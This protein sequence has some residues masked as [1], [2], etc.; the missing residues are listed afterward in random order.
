LDHYQ[1]FVI[2]VALDL[3][4]E[5]QNGRTYLSLYDADGAWHGYINANSVSIAAGPQGGW[6]ADSGYAT[7]T[8]AGQ[9]IYQGFDEQAATTSDQYLGQTF[10]ITG[11]YHWFDGT[12]YVSLYD[13][14]GKWVGYMAA[15]SFTQGTNAQGP[16]Q[17]H[18][19]WV[20]VAH[21]GYQ[22]WK[23]FAFTHYTKAAANQVVEVK[24]VYHHVNGSIYDSVYDADGHWLGYVNA[25]AVTPIADPIGQ[26]KA[27]DRYVTVTDKNAQV[28]QDTQFTKSDSADALYQHTYHVVGEYQHVNGNTYLVLHD[29]QDQL[30]GIVSA[31]SVAKA[32]GPQGVWLGASGYVTLN[33]ENTLSSDF[34][35]SQV[36]T[37]GS[38]VAG[39]TYKVTGQ[40]HTFDGRV[41]YSVY[42]NKQWLGYIDSR[43]VKLVASQTGSW[44][45]KTG[46][47]TTT[48]KGEP[49][50]RSFFGSSQ[51]TSSH[52][53]STY[54]IKGQ[55]HAYTG[56]TYYS[57]YA[58]NGGWLGYINA[59]NGAFASGPQGAWMAHSGKVTL[60]HTGYPIWKGFFTN[61][62]NTT[63]KL[64][65]KQYSATGEYHHFNGSVYYSLYS[66]K[67]WIGYVN[68]AATTPTKKS[69]W[70]SVN[71]VLK[72]YDQTKA[73][74]TK[75]FSLVYYS[76]LDGRWAGK[77]YGGINFGKTGCGQA[78]IAMI[79]SG[80]GHKITPSQAADY[81]HRYGTF[82]TPGEVGSAESDLTKVAD[83][84]GVKWQV[85]SSRSQLQSYLQKGYP[86]TVCLNLS[87]GVRHIVVLTGYSN[88][89]TTVHDPW[90]GLLFS[91]RH[92]L[93][94]VWSMLSWKSDNT[95]MGASAAVV[96]IG[97]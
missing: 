16:F 73:K 23:S 3:K 18:T 7:L 10:K 60:S 28:F 59:N 21:P 26:M 93:S 57:L 19:E 37:A 14:T 34:D 61:Q 33:G 2:I 41:L 47:F 96:Y 30:V 4:I 78:S 88:G 86:A 89:T 87:G 35:L 63:T 62:V 15:G 84:Y 70:Y 40:Y 9:P 25:K 22:I 74:Y 76:Q 48:K 17:A 8:Q 71:G 81:S 64:H 56:A 67:T 1:G 39:N 50:W 58:A 42:A 68:A 31:K 6:L 12:V 13:G 54:Q 46:Y 85:M 38:T 77:S 95:N 83:H 53:Q 36:K 55:Y 91:G 97:K 51:S 43:K 92:S 82:D 24:G 69:G 52:Y 45:S 66:G 29:S 79:V 44:I 80:F 94:Q 5:D 72:Y 49:I 65:N 90:S 32:N 20:S 27:A 11:A 75:N